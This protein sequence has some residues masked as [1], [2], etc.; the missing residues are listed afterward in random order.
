MTMTLSHIKL[1]HFPFA[2]I[3]LLVVLNVVC[4]GE[5]NI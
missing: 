2:E 5:K 1:F 4:W 3:S